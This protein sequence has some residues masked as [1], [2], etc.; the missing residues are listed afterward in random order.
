MRRSVDRLAR[1]RRA[2][3]GRATAHALALTSLVA[4]GAESGDG[5]PPDLSPPSEMTIISKPSTPT[6]APLPTPV[7]P[8]GSATPGR[9]MLA[10]PGLTTP[11]TRP[12]VPSAAPKPASESAP[13][14]LSL[15]APIE[16]KPLPEAL[17]GNPAANSSRSNLPLVLDSS[18]MDDP[19][20]TTRSTPPGRKPTTPAQPAP[21]PARR[22]RLFGFLAGPSPAPSSS[23]TTAAK[24]S[25]PG[26]AIV[27]DDPAVESALKRRIERQAREVVG[28]R[29]R[30][31]EVKLD[32]KDAV[33]QVSGVKMF[34]K[35]AIRKQ[36]EG[37]PAL[38]GLRS[39][40]EVA[41]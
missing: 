18:T 30:S 27:G 12:S 17:P 41:D 22:P 7:K 25:T 20:P 6:P 24:P 2:G 9:P 13:G 15:D 26:R 28:N 31:V 37:I 39:T 29:A 23:A 11:S 5:D 16:M 8:P 19:S 38:A 35:R 14:E 21:M 36:L 10:I 4:A 1:D 33:V 32:G 3:L 40:I 34:Q